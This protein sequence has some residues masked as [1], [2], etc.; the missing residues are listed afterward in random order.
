MHAA[1]WPILRHLQAYV[2]AGSHHPPS[3]SCPLFKATPARLAH[4][5]V[6]LL[7]VS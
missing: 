6:G 1:A 4:D 2:E 3:R 7:D 5:E